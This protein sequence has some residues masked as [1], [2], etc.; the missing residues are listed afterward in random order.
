MPNPAHNLRIHNWLLKHDPGRLFRG[1]IALGLSRRVGTTFSFTL[2][3]YLAAIITSILTARLLGPEGRGQY[4]VVFL[5][6]TTLA[7]ATM[8]SIGDAAGVAAAKARGDKRVIDAIMRRAFSTAVAATLA[9]LLPGLALFGAAMSR[10]GVA[11]T[12]FFYGFAAVTI[13]STVANTVICNYQR[14]H[15]QYLHFNF[16]RSIT[17]LLFCLFLVITVWFK[18]GRLSLEEVLSVLLAAVMAG[19]LLTAVGAHNL[20]R[21]FRWT[22][23]DIVLLARGVGMHGP[24]LLLI[25]SSQID[26]FVGMYTLSAAEFGLFAAAASV[27][28]PPSALLIITLRALMIGDATLQDPLAQRGRLRQYAAQVM[29]AIL[30]ISPLAALALYYVVPLAFGREFT[31]A[32][33][34]AVWLVLGYALAPVRV[35]LLELGRITQRN[36]K[37]MM[38]EIIYMLTVLF[39]LVVMMREPSGPMFA[40]ALIAGNVVAIA[41]ALTWRYLDAP[42]VAETGAAC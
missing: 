2:G 24:V 13:V 9:L 15:G 18:I 20:F 16:A 35:L 33:Q 36:A 41:A 10:S 21:D 12:P 3:N 11:P 32:A 31:A 5:W 22:R 6:A 39:V 38:I 19:A 23:P 8:L 42:K 14:A 40:V 28:Q 37:A 4:A 26:R 17:L 27:A 29:L 1:T 25:V 34:T 30:I 7:A